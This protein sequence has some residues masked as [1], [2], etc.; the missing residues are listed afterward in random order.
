MPKPDKQAFH[1]MVFI[2]GSEFVMGSEKKSRLISPLKKVR[3]D[4]FY[5]DIYPV[6]NADYASVVPDWDFDPKRHN[7]PAVGL[8]R[9]EILRYCASKG[10]RLPTEDENGLFRE[11]IG[12]LQ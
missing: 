10:K 5:M 7:Y 6:T 11:M 2:L 4:P 1:Q 9:D 12:L 3:V 8:S